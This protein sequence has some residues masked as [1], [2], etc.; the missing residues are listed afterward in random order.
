MVT[1]LLRKIFHG[2]LISA[3]EI[4]S[5]RFPRKIFLE[6]NCA[7]DNMILLLKYFFKKIFLNFLSPYTGPSMVSTH[8][9]IYTTPFKGPPLMR[10]IFPP[11]SSLF[12]K[13]VS[14]FLDLRISFI[15]LFKTFDSSNHVSH[16][17]TYD[18]SHSPIYCNKVCHI[19]MQGGQHS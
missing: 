7:K 4:A 19:Y 16:V 2:N 9:N 3:N 12:L 11:L 14:L 5:F 15:K 8:L 1:F 17:M 10:N 6:R 18:I 13:H